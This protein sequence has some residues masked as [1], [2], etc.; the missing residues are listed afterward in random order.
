MAN[1]TVS[2]SS[3]SHINGELTF[4]TATKLCQQV[5]KLYKAES[6]MTI[7]LAQVEKCDSASLVLLLKIIENYDNSGYKVV[8]TNIPES[9]STLIRLYNLQEII[10]AA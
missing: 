4:Y 5:T 7:D 1:I 6:D 2:N 10:K 9:I 3:Q 8:F